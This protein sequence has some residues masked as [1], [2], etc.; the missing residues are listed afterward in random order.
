MQLQVHHG[1]KSDDR[2]GRLSC[3]HAVAAAAAA[4]AAAVVARTVAGSVGD[5][6]KAAARIAMDAKAAQAV[7]EFVRVSDAA[8]NAAD[9]AKKAA[10]SAF[11]SDGCLLL[12]GLLLQRQ[13]NPGGLLIMPRR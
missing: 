5:G 10:A 1:R 12:P 13:P 3:N 2:A 4:A 7:A 11:A 9:A 6:T 8:T